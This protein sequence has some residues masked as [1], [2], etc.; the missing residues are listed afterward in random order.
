MKTIVRI[1]MFFCALAVVLVGI[2]Y[3]FLRVH[4]SSLTIDAPGTQAALKTE[5]RTIPATIN[6]IIL[7]GPIDLN[8]QQA[9]KPTLSVKAAQNFLPRITTRIDGNVLTIST[10]GIFF[11]L[12]S[13][14]QVDLSLPELGMLQMNGSG[15]VKVQG[16]KGKNLIVAQR[17]SGNLDLSADYLQ[18]QATMNG[19]GNAELTLANSDKVSLN[20]SGSGNNTLHGQGKSLELHIVG[21]GDLSAETFTADQVSLEMSGSGDAS[22]LARQQITGHL[23]G[24][25][26]AKV[27]GNPARR[28][29]S[30]SGSGEINWH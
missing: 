10:N 23:T 13:P 9:A 27:F 5:N 3:S 7:S 22:V 1:A 17:G 24:S 30:K 26:E 25:G 20:I 11:N 8:L 21:S 29:V 14:L 12:R 6:Q 15:E 16:F 28:N 19:S 2:T 18:V 4:A